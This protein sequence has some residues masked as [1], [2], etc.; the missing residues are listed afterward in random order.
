MN[1]LPILPAILID[2][3]GS[4][5]NIVFSFLATWYA[6]RLTRLRPNN[7]LWGYL[8]YVNLAIAAFATS[9]AVGHISR[10]L[11][12]IAGRGDVWQVIGPYSGGFNTLFMISV[13][14]VMIFYHKGVQAYEALGEEAAKL[15]QS[16][17]RLAHAARQLKE[18]NLNLEEKVEERTGELSKSE[19]KFRHLFTTSKDM[20]FFTDS[21][22]NIVDM[23]SAGYEMLGYSHVESIRLNLRDIFLHEGDVDTYAS[24]LAR[25]SF[26]S[27]LEA[28]FLKKDD[29]TIYVLIS[30]T[31]LY[32]DEGNITGSEGI[33]KD[34]TRLKT[35]MEQLVSS[36][37]MATVGQMAAGIAHEIN[38]PLGIILGYTQLMMDDFEPDSETYQNLVVIERQTKVS[39]KIVADLLKYSRQSG[40]ARESVNCNEILE[41]SAAVTEH[42]L[43]LSHIK[44]RLEL[45][46]DLPLIV[47]DPE[48]LRQVIVNLINNAHHA[49]EA[50]GGGELLLATGVDRENGRVRIEVRDT[51][52][53]IPDHIKARIFDPFFTTKAV[54]K[55]TGLGLSVSYGIIKEQEGTIEIESP[56][57]GPN[58]TKIPGT[59]FRLLL[60]FVGETAAVKQ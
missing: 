11:L 19:K 50:K 9:R 22:Q 49:M 18:L 57:I 21:K 40:S 43:N 23:N 25:D 6:F 45:A 26:V 60:P 31:A 24:M 28:E 14:A 34:L 30:A 10:E 12:Q 51:G 3:V 41:D 46:E 7:F 8:F 39:R 36:E 53:G 32:N 54:G 56:V 35:M 44:V 16:K 47:G 48:K 13:A 29:T 17:M 37:K 20:V 42:N 2:V 58:N 52:D 1:G 59:L 4:A 27:D 5:L 38:T 15:K 55:G 33:A